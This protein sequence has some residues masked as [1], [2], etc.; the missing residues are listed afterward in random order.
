MTACSSPTSETKTSPETNISPTKTSTCPLQL[1]IV[2]PAIG[3]LMGLL[4]LLLLVVVS[5]WVCTC[6]IMKKRGKMEINI[7]QDR[8]CLVL[9][10]YTCIV[11]LQKVCNEYKIPYYASI[12][13]RPQTNTSA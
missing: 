2:L 13:L 7:M 3:G 5:G 12:Y 10:D 1:N 4:I 9:K 11:K 8:Y 6:R